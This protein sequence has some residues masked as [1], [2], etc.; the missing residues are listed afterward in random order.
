[1]KIPSMFLACSIFAHA[2]IVEGACR[3]LEY[4]EIKDTKTAELVKTYC[5]YGAVWKLATDARAEAN[6]VFLEQVKQN[7]NSVPLLETAQRNYT[8]ADTMYAGDQRSCSEQREKIATAL[9]ARGPRVDLSCKSP[10][11]SPSKPKP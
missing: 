1:M 3:T 9:K 2:S 8:S 4:A 11:N 7:A 5:Y 6:R 10:P